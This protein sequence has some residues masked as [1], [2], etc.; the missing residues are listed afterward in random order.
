[1]LI[2]NANHHSLM[3]RLMKETLESE[4]NIS[5]EEVLRRLTDD[6]EFRQRRAFEMGEKVINAQGPGRNLSF[7]AT[8]IGINQPIR[9]FQQDVINY[10]GNEPNV[11]SKYLFQMK[12]DIHAEGNRII[13]PTGDKTTKS[14]TVIT[15]HTVTDKDSSQNILN[16][17][18]ERCKKEN[19]L[20]TQCASSPT[21]LRPIPYENVFTDYR[22]T[23]AKIMAKL[24]SEHSVDQ[25]VIAT[26]EELQLLREDIDRASHDIENAV[27]RRNEIKAEIA[28]HTIKIQEASQKVQNT[29]DR[30]MA[31]TSLTDAKNDVAFMFSLLPV[32]IA[33]F[34]IFLQKD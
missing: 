15:I 13:T 34:G 3:E 32:A 1:M 18:I 7:D 25:S 4:H 8:I 6:D 21:K 12:T 29:L 5:T 16:Y 26:V 23:V 9:V 20:L 14:T 2:K 22:D 30:P 11:I 27:K 28:A 33:L 24:K 17:L 31:A 10:I 19:H